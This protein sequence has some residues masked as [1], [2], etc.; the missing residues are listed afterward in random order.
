MSK[1]FLD[2]TLTKN[3]WMFATQIVMLKVVVGG[4]GCG[5]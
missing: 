4:G 1:I 5:S 2:A 3:L